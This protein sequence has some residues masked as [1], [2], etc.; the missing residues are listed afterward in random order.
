MSQKVNWKCLLQSISYPI[1]TAAQRVYVEC[2]Y[3]AAAETVCA[4][5]QTKR[6]KLGKLPPF[7]ALSW[8]SSD[9]PERG[10]VTQLC[11]GKIQT[12]RSRC[13]L[14]TTPFLPVVTRLVGLVGGALA[15][16]IWYLASYP[17]ISARS[18]FPWYSPEVL[19]TTFKTKRKQFVFV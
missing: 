18:D 11:A 3:W 1:Q 16:I 13:S 5:A 2:V 8:V 6:E 10:R 17:R 14:V 9:V 15:L 12:A 19:L 4:L 7:S